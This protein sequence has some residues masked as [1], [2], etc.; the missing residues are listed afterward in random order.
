MWNR[1][2][3]SRV[4]SV[5]MSYL[6]GACGMT[7]WEGESNEHVYERFCLGVCSSRVKYGMVEWVI[8]KTVMRFGHIERINIEECVKKVYVSEIEGLNRRGRPL[9]R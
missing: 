1:A 5:E 4:H 9:R 3:Q 7:R 2:Q 6:R 8:R